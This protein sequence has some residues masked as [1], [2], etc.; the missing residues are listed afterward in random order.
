MLKILILSSCSKIHH[1]YYECC[2]P[3]N[4]ISASNWMFNNNG[5]NYSVTTS[6]FV[7]MERNSYIE[8]CQCHHKKLDNTLDVFSKNFRVVPCFFFLKSF[9]ITAKP[10]HVKLK[11]PFDDKEE[12][13]IIIFH[14]D[15]LSTWGMASECVTNCY[16]SFSINRLFSGNYIFVLEKG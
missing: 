9:S 6:L 14:R 12:M 16:F 15:I 10:S 5:K 4:N 1:F 8:S 3:P 13:S 11:S 7:Y 2:L